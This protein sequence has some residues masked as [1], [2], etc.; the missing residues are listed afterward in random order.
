MKEKKNRKR[1]LNS[2]DKKIGRYVKRKRVER[3]KEKKPVK[4]QSVAAPLDETQVKVKRNIQREVFEDRRA[5]A[6]F[7]LDN[8]DKME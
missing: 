8:L 3:S 1:K 6:E 5:L 2:K 7:F 4:L